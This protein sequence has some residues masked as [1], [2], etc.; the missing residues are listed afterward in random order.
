MIAPAPSPHRRV[1]RSSAE[2]LR[3]AP[4]VGTML[5]LADCYERNGQ[6][7]ERLGGVPGRRRAVAARKGDKREALARQNATRLEA[8]LSRVL[9]RVPAEADVDGLVVKR[10][11]VNVGRAEWGVAVPVD[12][13]VTLLQG[14]TA[15]GWKVGPG[16]P[17]SRQRP[18][19]GFRPSRSRASR[20]RRRPSPHPLP[21][22]PRHPPRVS[23]RGAP[24]PRSASSRSPWLARGSSGWGWGAGFGLDG[25]V[26]ARRLECQRSLRCE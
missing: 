5:G 8:L 11:G 6:D 13:G 1:P 24:S 25:E 15:P 10:D 21:K 17:R 19:P 18:R 4:G 2:S 20:R 7:G 12:P 9:I 23:R 26:E 14:A 22:L 16:R 3:R